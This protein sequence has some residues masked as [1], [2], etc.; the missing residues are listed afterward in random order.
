VLT[1]NNPAA[2]HVYD[3]H[4]GSCIKQSQCSDIL[5]TDFKMPRMSGIELLQ[6]QFLRDCK[7]DKKNKAV[8]SGQ[9]D[10]ENKK[11]INK[12]GCAFFRKPFELSELSDWLNECEKRMDLSKTLSNFD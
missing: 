1:C 9:I 10:N 11:A 5:I 4:S 2:C 12:L 8:I 7:L 6:A 3:N